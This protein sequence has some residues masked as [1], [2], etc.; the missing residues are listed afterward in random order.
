MQKLEIKARTTTYLPAYL[1]QQLTSSSSLHL[2]TSL[3]V[4]YANTELV[5]IRK[6]A[7][8]STR[9]IAFPGKLGQSCLGCSPLSAE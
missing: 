8:A 3:E 9:A 7:P 2:C 4:G 6:P 1:Y 5:W